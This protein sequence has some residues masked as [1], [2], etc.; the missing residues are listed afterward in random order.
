[1]SFDDTAKEPEQSFSLSRD[2][3]GELEYPTKYETEPG[4]A[5]A[6]HRNP[7]QAPRFRGGSAQGC[8]QEDLPVLPSEF[9]S[10]APGAG[11][12]GIPGVQNHPGVL[13]PARG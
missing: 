4:A 10:P 5:P 13:P 11:C 1:M 2:P 6:W 9:S 12:V 7:V 3:L 8:P